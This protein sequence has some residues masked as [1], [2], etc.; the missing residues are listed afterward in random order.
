MK[1]NL[2][3]WLLVSEVALS[4]VFCGAC[5]NEKTPVATSPGEPAMMPLIEYSPTPTPKITVD[6]QDLPYYLQT[7]LNEDHSLIC[8]S[9]V[10]PNLNNL[11]WSEPNSRGIR[12]VTLTIYCYNAGPVPMRVTPTY[13]DTVTYTDGELT[14]SVSGNSLIQPG[15][16][17][18]FNLRLS[19]KSEYT[20][21]GF[22]RMSFVAQ[23]TDF[24]LK[25]NVSPV[26]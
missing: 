17:E 18:P 3:K 25:F 21:Y 22:L 13:K 14:L 24:N 11:N 12:R 20:E 5:L 10:I 2:I 26:P 23:P 8:D 6:P 4:V 9:A 15:T 16:H 1:N 7:Y 19:F